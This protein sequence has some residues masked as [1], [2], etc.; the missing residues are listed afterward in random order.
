MAKWFATSHVRGQ[1]L[2]TSCR[3]Y[4]LTKGLLGTASDCTRDYHPDLL[5]LRGLSNQRTVTVSVRARP[6][7]ST[8]SSTVRSSRSLIDAVTETTVSWRDSGSGRLHPGFGSVR[9]CSRRKPAPRA[10]PDVPPRPNSLCQPPVSS[11]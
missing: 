1:K 8:R 5:R 11:V 2:R 4:C 9:V 6:R 7:K 3:I 10:E